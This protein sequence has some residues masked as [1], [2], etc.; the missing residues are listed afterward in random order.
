[1]MTNVLLVLVGLA[2]LAAVEAVYYL[3]RYAGERQRAELRRRLR[4]IDEPG[5]LRLERTGK[6]CRNRELEPFIRALP[7]SA[8]LEQL[9]LQT[10]L[11][12]TVASML[13]SAVLTGTVAFALA[14]SLAAGAPELSVLALIA[15]LG[16]PVIIALVVRQRRSRVISSQ[17]PEA[18][19]MM[20]RSLRAGHGVSAAFKLVATE[21]PVPIAVE[22]AR[23]F[24]EHNLGVDFRVAVE[25]LTKRVPD[26][27]DLRI[28]AMSVVLQHETGGNLV[29]ILEQIAYTIRERYKFYGKLAALTA[30]GKVSGVI[31]GALPVGVTAVLSVTNGSYLSVLVEDPTG[32]MV[33]LSGL[34]LWASGVAWLVR[35]TKVE[36]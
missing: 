27:L 24:D 1:M 8:E 6:L 19:D 12:W 2:C 32:R 29:E 7:F 25:N 11:E 9:L 4:S 3:F 36:Y 22:F 14:L 33:A 20:V 31:L 35:L 10:D 23:C 34:S 15:G 28:F 30:E 17:L 16:A 13:G 26:N 21:M 5:A 18:L